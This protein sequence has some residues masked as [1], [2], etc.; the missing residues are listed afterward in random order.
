MARRNEQCAA[1]LRIPARCACGVQP[2]VCSEPTPGGVRQ[3]KAV[4]RLKDKV[5]DIERLFQRKAREKEWILADLP[6]RTSY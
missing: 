4:Q 5:A 1:H 6:S 2:C 3:R